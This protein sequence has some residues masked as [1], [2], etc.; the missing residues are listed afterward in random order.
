MIK[1]GVVVPSDK[2]E[3]SSLPKKKD[4]EESDDADLKKEIKES[5][6]D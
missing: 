4:L 1:Y 6:N 2:L 5:N 3:E